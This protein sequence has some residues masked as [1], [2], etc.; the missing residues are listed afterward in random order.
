MVSSGR[1]DRDRV[2]FDQ[3]GSAATRTQGLVWKERG[4]VEMRMLEC[5]WQ[6]IRT[7][8]T[9]TDEISKLIFMLDISQRAQIGLLERNVIWWIRSSV[10]AMGEGGRNATG[11]GVGGGRTGLQLIH[12]DGRVCLCV[13]IAPFFLLVRF[14]EVNLIPRG[15]C[16]ARIVGFDAETTTP[17]G[18]GGNG[19]LGGGHFY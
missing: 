17:A 6:A 12:G 8:E 9:L 7:G 10:K 15:A 19:R 14:R 13:K 11:L 5:M 1:S 18:R 2:G 3:S 16:S 4:R